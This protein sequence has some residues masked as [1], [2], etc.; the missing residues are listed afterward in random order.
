MKCHSARRHVHSVFRGSFGGSLSQ[1]NRLR[2]DTLTLRYE[3]H[4]P[5]FEME[6]SLRRQGLE[7]I[8]ITTRVRRTPGSA[9][10]KQPST[11]FTM[12]EWIVCC[13]PTSNLILRGVMSS[14]GS[15]MV[16][17]EDSPTSMVS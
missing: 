14:F 15:L 3:R 1:M 13:I 10:F 16:T 9:R 17:W 7:E 6:S 12:Y 8:F 2:V 11:P 4:T 5:A